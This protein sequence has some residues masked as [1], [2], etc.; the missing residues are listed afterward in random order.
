MVMIALLVRMVL[1][2]CV[3]RGVAAP[4]FDHNE[5][6][7]EMGWTARS[8]ALGHG[9][10]SPFLPWTGPTALVPP[11][12]PWLL[13]AVFH[14]W[15]LYTAQ[16]ALV[17]LSLNSVFSALTCIPI[18]LSVRRTLGDRSAMIA[19][20]AWV[21]YPYAVYFSAGRVWD[22]ALTGLLFSICFWAVQRIHLH[23]RLSTW[24]ALGALF[25]V[26][27]LSNPSV[28]TS[29]VLLLLLAAYKVRSV[30]GPWLLRSLITLVA[31]AAV[32]APWGLRNYRALHAI[33][34]VRD[35]L[36]L[37]VWAG[38][39]GDTFESNPGWAHPASN[40]VEMQ[41]FQALGETAY[42]AQKKD[43]A[44]H[45]VRTNPRLFAVLC[46]RRAVRFWTG[47]WSLSRPYLAIE[48]FDI[49]NIFFCTT[50]TVLML[51]GLRRLW[52]VNRQSAMAYLILLVV[53]PIPYYL[54]HCSTDYRQ[55][56]ESPILALVT[57][58]IFGFGNR[59]EELP[60]EIDVEVE[61]PEP[62][63]VMARAYPEPDTA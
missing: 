30:G 12:F 63:L 37:E 60:D 20:W 26:T 13:A 44:L 2:L 7:W 16:S 47:L 18:Y 49:P 55:P 14:I 35:G 43:L 38:N 39:N 6:G 61:E 48:P 57:F 59:R 5:F 15:G 53:F 42:M 40:P 9:F 52:N 22:Y 4:T 8:I 50:L 56:I 24:F 17:V 46:V 1:V 23:S 33:T 45:F 62:E 51:R 19:G 41:R 10:G 54:S 3:F 31:F 21:I 27:C 58:G 36:W 29:L 28:A 25:G 11:L 34:P 32:L